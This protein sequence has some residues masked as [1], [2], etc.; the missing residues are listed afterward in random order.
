MEEGPECG[1]F[2]GAAP[3]RIGFLDRTAVDHGTGIVDAVVDD[4]LRHGAMSRQRGD[5]LNSE[6]RVCLRLCNDEDERF[7]LCAYEVD[8]APDGAKVVG[9]RAGRNEDKVSRGDDSSNGIGDGWW[10]VDHGDSIA[11]CP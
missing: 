2:L 6:A 11:G 3:F 5:S 1:H 9:T 4:C 10:R 8:S 7:F